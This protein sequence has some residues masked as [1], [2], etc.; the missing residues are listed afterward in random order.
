MFQPEPY[1]TMHHKLGIL[2]WV[3]F[4][5][6][7]WCC[8][9]WWDQSQQQYNTYT[10]E[11][12]NTNQADSFVSGTNAFINSWLRSMATQGERHNSQKS[13]PT[14]P[15]WLHPHAQRTPWCSRSL[16]LEIRKTQLHP[17]TVKINSQWPNTQPSPQ[18]YNLNRLF[19]KSSN[20]Q[21]YL[22]RTWR[23]PHSS[24]F[25]VWGLLWQ[26]VIVISFAR[27]R[28]CTKWLCT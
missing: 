1:F 4:Y 21:D 16:S 22:F 24:P 23:H 10:N 7:P 25:P 14:T 6:K 15:L 17:S 2:S 19:S 5:Y 26:M 18:Q 12:T 9:P 3:L 20:S 13:L 11:N 27:E 28:N 8:I